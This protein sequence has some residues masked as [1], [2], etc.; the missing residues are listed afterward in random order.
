MRPQV[1]LTSAVVLPNP[2]I[3]PIR[4]EP[5]DDR[6][7]RRAGQVST[8]LTRWSYGRAALVAVGDE[9][10]FVLHDALLSSC[11]I[12]DLIARETGIKLFVAAA[13]LSRF[14]WQF[15]RFGQA[16]LRRPELVEPNAEHLDGQP[17]RPDVVDRPLDLRP[18]LRALVA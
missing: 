12:N 17:H 6:R 9:G 3:E 2:K 5:V 7:L 14:K 4:T 8:P 15:L 1:G 13:S 11:R 18:R 10:V 16:V